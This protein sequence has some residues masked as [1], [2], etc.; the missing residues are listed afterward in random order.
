[1][2]VAFRLQKIV[3]TFKEQSFDEF[4]LNSSS[5]EDLKSLFSFLFDLCAIVVVL[6]FFGRVHDKMP[7]KP[8]HDLAKSS[9]NF[10]LYR[11]DTTL[12]HILTQR[13]TYF[14][15]NFYLLL[16]ASIFSC[17]LSVSLLLM[18]FFIV[19]LCTFVPRFFSVQAMQ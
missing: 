12:L 19:V 13:H 15:T 4:C 5:E 10:F 16:R 6:F 8:S 3:I 17:S 11:V 14:H 1:M 7:L 2:V 18:S 9:L